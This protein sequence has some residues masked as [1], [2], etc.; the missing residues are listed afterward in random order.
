MLS[1]LA[2]A[3][4]GGYSLGEIAKAIIII[5]AVV[6]IVYVACKAMGV[7]VPPWLVQII[8][9]VVIAIIAIVAISIVLSL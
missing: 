6:A 2:A 9:I 5:L 8:V 4:L 1:L 3:A 7:E